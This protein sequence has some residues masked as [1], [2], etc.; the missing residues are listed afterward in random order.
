M[1]L[2][3]YFDF[4]KYDFMNGSIDGFLPLNIVNFSLDD[5]DEPFFK[6]VSRYLKP[7]SLIAVL[8]SNPTLLNASYKSATSIFVK[9]WTFKKSDLVLKINKNSFSLP[10]KWVN[11]KCIRNCDH[12]WKQ[13]DTVYSHFVTVLYS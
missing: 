4:G 9:E 12:I 1:W 5:I 8:F 11:N 7:R 3:I 6:N 13:I 2:L 10:T